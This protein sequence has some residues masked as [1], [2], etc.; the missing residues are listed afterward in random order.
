MSTRSQDYS[1]L[2]A[3]GGPVVTT[4]QRTTAVVV[5]QLPRRPPRIPVSQGDVESL[6]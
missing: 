3:T 1:E 5:Y 4:N 6:G 2:R